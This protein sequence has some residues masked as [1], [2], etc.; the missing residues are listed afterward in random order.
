MVL[1]VSAPVMSAVAVMIRLTMGNP[2]LFRQVRPGCRERPFCLL[3]FRTMEDVSGPDGQPRPDFERL[4]PLGR[5]LRRTSLDELPQLWNVLKGEM[6]LVGPRPLLMRYLPYFTERERLRQTVKPG[7][8]GW[9]QIRGRNAASW[10][11][12]L[13]DDAWY[14]ENWSLMLD[15]KILLITLKVAL[16]GSGV[17]VDPRSTM[18]DL[19]EERAVRQQPLCSHQIRSTP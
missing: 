9:A 11:Q 4:T 18:L 2:V 16:Y 19:D 8:T 13:S 7:I 14:V 10:D 17:V 15:L 3:K 5:F 12:R 1:L 6:S